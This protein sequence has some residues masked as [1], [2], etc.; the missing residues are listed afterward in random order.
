MSITD[1]QPVNA[2]ASNAAWISKNTNDTAVAQI[3]FNSGVGSDGPIVPSIQQE[4]N[5]LDTFTGRVSGTAYNALPP[6]TT[7]A[8]G[9]SSDNLE[10][11]SEALTLKF[12]DTGANGG[13]THTGVDGDAPQLQAASIAGI[14]SGTQAIS[15]ST[16]SQAVTFSS[17]MPST[18]YSITA[19]MS[20]VVDAYP[21]FQPIVVTSKTTTGFTASWNT[22]TD[23]ANYQLEWF[24]ATYV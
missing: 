15:I 24:V 16:T 14:R 13:H 6:W 11:R 17:A 12:R 19:C 18:S 8:V 23:S 5:S 10:M 9:T 22:N 7:S 2:A 1:G 20:N 4:V 3:S 21:E